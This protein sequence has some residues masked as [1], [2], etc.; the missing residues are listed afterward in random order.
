MGSS[1]P[2]HVL[3]TGGTDGI[4]LYLA[5]LYQSEGASVAVT[6]RRNQTEI[7]PQL[8]DRI[9][10]IKA[11]QINPVQAATNIVN[12]LAAMGW[13]SCDIAILN[14]GCGKVGDPLEETA[15]SIRQIIDVNLAATVQIAHALSPLLLAN[16]RA[17]QA[18]GKLVIIGSTAH[19]GAQKFASYAATKAGLHGLARSLRVEWCGRVDVKIIH[20]GPTATSLHEKAGFDP[21]LMSRLF[22]KPDQ[23]A[24]LV[25]HRASKSGSPVS[26]GFLAKL[27]DSITPSAWRLG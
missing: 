14:A 16:A 6:G 1:R 10:Y 20:P 19:K 25:K 9:A 4:G 21:G 27:R 3:I 24:R 26:I 12:G 17:R 18:P 13:K 11:D 23:M 5:K 2:A 15:D 7:E 22:L 8:C